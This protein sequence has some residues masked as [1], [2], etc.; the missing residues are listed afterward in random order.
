MRPG[1]WRAGLLLG[2]MTLVGCVFPT[3]DVRVHIENGTDAPVAVYVNGGWVGTYP[4]GTT[5]SAPIAGHGG[6]PY[7]V[8]SE[9]PGGAVLTTTVIAANDA[10]SVASG[11][12]VIETSV[13]VGCGHVRIVIATTAAY[14]GTTFTEPGACPSP[15]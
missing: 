9:G 14:E 5:T 2:A 11:S 7:T 6:P 8:V 13:G 3:G 4:A 15:S 10:P 12:T 1:H